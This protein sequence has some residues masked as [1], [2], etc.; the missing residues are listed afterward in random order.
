LGVGGV[1][2]GDQ[3]GGVVTFEDG[4]AGFAELRQGAKLGI[5]FR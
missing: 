5:G 3:G 4:A 1:E 2:R